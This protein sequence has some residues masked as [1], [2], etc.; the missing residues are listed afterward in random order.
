MLLGIRKE[1]EVEKVKIKKTEGL[2]GVELKV[3]GRKWSVIRVYVRGDMERKLEE[4]NEWVEKKE[5][6]TSILIGENFNVRTN[7][8]EGVIRKG[9]EEEEGVGRR[10]KDK[11]INK[12][13]KELLRW[14]GKAGWT[15]FNGCTKADKGGNG[16]E[17]EWTYTGESGNSEI[18]YVLG[19]EDIRMLVSRVEV[20]D[21]IDS[22]H[23]PIIVWIEKREEKKL[24]RKERTS[25]RWVWTQEGKKEFRKALGN[26]DEVAGKVDEVWEN[27]RDKIKEVMISGCSSKGEKNTVTREL[28][29]WRE[30]GGDGNL[31]REAK[32]KYKKFI[33]EKKKEKRETWERELREIRTGGQVWEISSVRTKGR[34]MDGEESLSRNEIRS[35][36]GR[37]KDNK[38]VDLD[39]I[40]AE[41][42]KY[43]EEPR[44][45]GVANMQ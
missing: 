39:G 28:R 33:E 17:G 14:I 21:N 34:N 4:L 23:H 5:E 7:E 8:E 6:N 35:A 10:S 20:G 42:W 9:H 37:Q 1:L 44:V 13:G 45:M 27:M 15:I 26:V 22:D 2:M 25:K 18:D 11:R 16:M 36:I 12:K 19:D 38:A 24:K 31:Y 41:V 30:K 29:R 3:K 40:P 32:G 43:G